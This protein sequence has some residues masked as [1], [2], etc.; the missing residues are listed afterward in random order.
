MN[1]DE[2]INE[3]KR[4]VKRTS[5]LE[6]ARRVEKTIIP[7]FALREVLVNAIVHRDYSITGS[8]IKIKMTRRLRQQI[9]FQPT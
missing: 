5:M 2:I 1:I 3:M 7:D 9:T 8:S 6:G 4:L